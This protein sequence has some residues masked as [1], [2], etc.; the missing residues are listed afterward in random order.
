MT[1]EQFDVLQDRLQS[2][3]RVLRNNG[4]YLQ[5][6]ARA[7]YGVYSTASFV[8][9]HYEVR[10]IRRH[11]GESFYEGTF[12]HNE[13]VDLVKVLYDGQNSGDVEAGNAPGITGARLS[14]AEAAKKTNALQKAR[15][16]A[17]Y[18]PTDVA[19]PFSRTETDE[20]LAWADDISRD[21]RRLL[22]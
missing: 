6:I 11:Q 17:D 1:R 4:C 8:A 5:A 7:Y 9:E 15:K 19:E 22:K 13:A 16:L 20:Y 10:A 3:V 14:P 21:L 2:A 12:S 18:G